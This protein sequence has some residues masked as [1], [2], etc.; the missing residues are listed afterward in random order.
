MSDLDG[1]IPIVCST[2]GETICYTLYAGFSTAKC[3]KCQK[4]DGVVDEAKP[5]EVLKAEGKEVTTYSS[6]AD[7][8]VET[9]LETTEKVI[10]KVR[11]VKKKRTDNRLGLKKGM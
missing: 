3:M 1:T 11:S 2:C 4:G 10:A 9:I 5:L 7:S 8:I 6:V